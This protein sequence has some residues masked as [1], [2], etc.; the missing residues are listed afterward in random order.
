MYIV[1]FVLIHKNNIYKLHIFIT[2]FVYPE[3]YC[4][5]NDE[6]GLTLI[7]ITNTKV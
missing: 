1:L 3:L 7:H 2:T 4:Q 6:T 5:E